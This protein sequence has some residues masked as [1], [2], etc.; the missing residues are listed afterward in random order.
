MRKNQK[1]FGLVEILLLI[2]AAGL[3]SGAGWY[4]Y[5]THNSSANSTAKS[6]TI[7][8]KELGIKLTFSD[9]NHWSYNLNQGPFK[10]ATFNYV[11]WGGVAKITRY[12]SLTTLDE[13][14]TEQRY[15]KHIGDFYVN[16]TKLG[17]PCSAEDNQYFTQ[18][19][20]AFNTTSAD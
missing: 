2:V 9:A 19:V 16:L 11:G 8:V 3:I 4:V 1:G 13:S 14:S 15:N 7:D 6:G 17:C 10:S 20:T 12:S 5:R 18:L